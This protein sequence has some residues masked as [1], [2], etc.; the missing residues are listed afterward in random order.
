MTHSTP[1]PKRLAYFDNIRAL[2]IIF[3]VLMH[4]AVTYSGFGGWYYKEEASLDFASTILFALFQSSLQAFFM[5]LL[6]MIAGYFSAAAVDR[7]STAQFINGRLLRL[8]IPTLF[9]MV[10]VQPICIK[11]LHPDLEIGKFLIDGITSGDI[12]SWSGPLWFAL[13]LLIFSLVYIAKRKMLPKLSIP[14]FLFSLKNVLFITAIITVIA[15]CVR[16]VF[17]IGSSVLNL[18]FGYYTAYVVFYIVGIL[19]FRYKALE[20]LDSKIGKKYILLAAA[21]GLPSWFLLMI[22]GGPADGEYFINGGWH[23][24]SI[25]F[26][27]WESFICVMVCIGLLGIFRSKFSSQNRL[28]KFLSDQA[29]GVY[30]FHAPILISISLVLKNLA[31]PPLL[32]FSLVAVITIPCCFIFSWIIKKAPGFKK[33]FA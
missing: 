5:S 2:M 8:G 6:F 32:K 18:Q 28:Q 25:A 17:P 16:L 15:F 20:S 31:L 13:T 30:V 21:I 1:L 12:L 9:Y 26:A 24:Q 19:S 22:L 23:W 14:P 3:V 7:K 33:V 10:I 29:F 4:V 11:I 27:L